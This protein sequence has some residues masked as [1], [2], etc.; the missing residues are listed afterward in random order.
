MPDWSSPTRRERR[1]AR[2]LEQIL[3]AAARLFAIQGY[4]RTT[5]KEIAEA[6]DVSEGTLYNYFDSKNELLFAIL[7]RLAKEQPT[8]LE[9]KPVAQQDVRH[10]LTSLLRTF[11]GSQEG[12][13]VMQQTILSEILADEAL[14]QRYYQRVMQPS[15]DAVEK[16]LKF[17]ISLGQIQ[18]VDPTGTARLLVSMALGLFILQ[19]LGDPVTTSDW[20]GLVDTAASIVSNG[21]E[22][23]K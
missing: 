21:L 23:S 6:A 16:L 10:L 14:R 18:P 7:A 9:A 5:T 17:K 12:Q 1:V 11:G 2:R 8:E 4:H 3:D 22:T 20:D 13:A 19:V 15:M